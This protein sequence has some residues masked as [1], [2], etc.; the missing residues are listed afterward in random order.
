MLD[1]HRRLVLVRVDREERLIL[2]G[3]GSLLTTAKAKS[4]PGGGAPS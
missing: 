4:A 1:P 2:L 3:E